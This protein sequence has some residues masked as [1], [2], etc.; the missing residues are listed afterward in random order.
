MFCG[1]KTTDIIYLNWKIAQAFF[2]CS[3][4][5]SIAIPASVT[6]INDYAFSGCSS[7][8]SI[9]FEA[10]STIETI[11]QGAFI[12]SG[13]TSIAIP[14]S[15]TS[16][17]AGAFENCKLLNTVNVNCS[18]PINIGTAAFQGLSLPFITLNIPPGTTAVYKATNVWKDFNIEET[19][20]STNS[21]SLNNNLQLYPNPAKDY[22]SISGLEDKENY[23]IYS[24]LGTKM[25][26][27]SI[28]KDEKINTQNLASGTYFLKF[29]QGNSVK[30]IKE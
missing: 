21:F 22:L 20:L 18:S 28:A 30:F 26:A 10:V 9:T 17:D 24:I 5:T 12:F 16:I 2:K 23:S 4:L 14:N 1:S 13:L 15:V 25:S 7:L 27:G 29:D 6:S 19:T 8:T 11:G 3:A